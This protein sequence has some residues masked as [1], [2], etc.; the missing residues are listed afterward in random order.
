MPLTA[1]AIHQEASRYRY[2]TVF[3]VE[4]ESLDRDGARARARAARRL[5][6][7]RR[8]RDRA[9]GSRPHRRPGRALAVGHGARR[10]R[11]G[12]DREHAPPD[13]RSARSGSRTPAD[14]DRRDD[15]GRRGRHRRGQ[16]PP[17]REHGRHRDRRRR[18]DDEP[19][20]RR[21]P[22]AIESA[23]APEVV[24]LPNNENVVLA[25]RQAAR[26]A[27]SQCTSSRRARSRPASAALSRTTRL[28]GAE[29][30]AKAMEDAAAA[31]ATG[32][33]TVARGR[34]AS[35]ACRS[36]AARGSASSAASR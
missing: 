10:H 14:D 32:G 35:T 23:H 34:S 22:A 24:V 19:V 18:R 36:S 8:R 30:N 2:C 12:R 31:V 29:A 7:R 6:A 11:A 3:V 25:A 16:S 13:A 21:A 26:L 33:V 15:R 28:A 4:G 17:L 20:D 5:A 9:Q 1:D 27:T